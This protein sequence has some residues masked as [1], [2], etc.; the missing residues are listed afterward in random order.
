M[1]KY[2]I[3]LTFL[4][5]SAC[6]QEPATTQVVPEVATTDTAQETAPWVENTHYTVLNQN[7]SDAPIV[8]EFFSFWCPHCYN[9]E[10]IVEQIKAQ[11]NSSTAFEKVH[12]DF[13]GFTSQDIQQGASKAM[14]MGRSM[15]I[16][17]R[18]NS[19]IFAHIHVTK[20]DIGGMADLKPLFLAN[21]VSEQAF[22]DALNSDE[23]NN[24]IDQHN[25]TFMQYRGDL[26]S[27]P[28]FIVNGQYMATFTRE[29]TID[30]MVAL[31]V[32]LSNK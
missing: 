12:V 1:K 16:E 14:L 18:I 19:A 31:I 32:W 23:V 22:N 21:G 11:L 4:M 26:K 17:T 6:S 7:A 27:V 10:P 20:K 15:G 25:A 9:F 24:L 5:L 29:M 2:F 13:M 30:D 8:Q 3:L 28:T